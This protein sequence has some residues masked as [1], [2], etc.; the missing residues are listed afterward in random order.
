MVLSLTT[1]R[2][3]VRGKMGVVKYIG[4]CELGD[5][6]WVGIE[7]SDPQAGDHDGTINRTKYFT[8]KPLQGL[9][10]PATEVC[11]ASM[12]LIGPGDVAWAHGRESAAENGIQSARRPAQMSVPCWPLRL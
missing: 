1:S 2:V 4:P 6:V 7:L 10:V 9:L 8:C 12:R 3:L 11:D 5:G